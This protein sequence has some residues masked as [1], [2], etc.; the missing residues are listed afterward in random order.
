MRKNIAVDYDGTYTDN[1]DCW[2]AVIVQLRIFGYSVYCVSARTN[3]EQ[4]NREL[5]NVLPNGVVLV[6]TGHQ[7]KKKFCEDLGINID[8]WIDNNPMALFVDDRTIIN[9][10]KESEQVQTMP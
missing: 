3:N 8:I 10:V 5:F 4:N 9:G 6:L 2:F 7:P 1:P